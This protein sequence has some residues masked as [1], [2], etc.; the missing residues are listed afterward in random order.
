M[1]EATHIYN[2]NGN[3]TY[4]SVTTWIHTHFS[5]FDA[6]EVIDR[7]MRSWK[8][9]QSKYRGMTK[10]QIK[11]QWKDNGDRASNAGTLMHYSIESFYNDNDVKDDSVEFSYFIQFHEAIQ[12][13]SNKPSP[14]RTEWQVYDEDNKLAGT[15]DMVYENE[16]GTLDLVD[17]KRCKEIKT[18]NK[19]QKAITPCLSHLPDTN[20]WQYS[21]QLNTYKYIIEKNYGK[22]IKAMFIVNIHPN[23]ENNSFL[24]F[25]VQNMQKQIK[26]L[27]K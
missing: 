22:K 7:M 6:D 14:Y 2:V 13:L 25:Q 20:F 12:R 11:K 8:W 17:W 5:E 21:L 3:L 1:D 23:N 26:E 4:M 15:I 9:S 24:M 27:L 16:D 10:D 18:E 19:W